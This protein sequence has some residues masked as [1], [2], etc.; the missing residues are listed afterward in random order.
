L[1]GLRHAR[2]PP[3]C[4]AASSIE[5]GIADDVPIIEVPLGGKLSLPPFEL[6][7]VTMTHSIPEPNAVAIRTPFGTVMHTGDWKIDPEPLIGEVTDEAALRRIGGEGVLA[8][9]CDSTNVF[10]EGESGSE[11]RCARRGWRR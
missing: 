1:S 8:M 7:F 10:V 2:S 4:C 6:E 11:V 5:A 3:R 9:I